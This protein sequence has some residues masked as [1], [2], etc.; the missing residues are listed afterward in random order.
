MQPLPEQ[1]GAQPQNQQNGGRAVAGIGHACRELLQG[2]QQQIGGEI[3]RHA[4]Q[5]AGG[6]LLE[7]DPLSAPLLLQ[8][9]QYRAEQHRRHKQPEKVQAV[10]IPVS[11]AVEDLCHGV[12]AAA[13]GQGQKQQAEAPSASGPPLPCPVRSQDHDGADG[14][15]DPRQLQAGGPLPKEQ[16]TDPQGHD[17]PQAG[18]G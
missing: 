7:A 14:Q 5:D 10:L 9:G 4:H 13:G 3:V 15:P 18:K 16:D 12:G 8:D 17:Q 1:E 11:E 6:E 2:A